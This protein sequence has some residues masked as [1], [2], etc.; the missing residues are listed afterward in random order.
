[1]TLQSLKNDDFTDAEIPVIDL[2]SLQA[3][4]ATDA[5]RRHVV[6]RVR[7]ACQQGWGI[8][9]IVKH[10]VVQNVVERIRNKHAGFRVL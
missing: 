4:G 10:G 1:M 5:A 3:G 7:E 2:A 8:L 9:E 6:S